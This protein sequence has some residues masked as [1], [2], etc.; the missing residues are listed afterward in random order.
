MSDMECLEKIMP[1]ILCDVCRNVVEI[2]P[3]TVLF[4]ARWYHKTCWVI[5][6]DGEQFGQSNSN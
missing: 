1:T 6:K 4:D 2:M 3:G 5:L